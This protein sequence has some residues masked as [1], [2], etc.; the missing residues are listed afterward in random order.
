MQIKHA[1]PERE[2]INRDKQ[3]PSKKIIILLYF[4]VEGETAELDGEMKR[5]YGVAKFPYSTVQ[6]VTIQS[7]ALQRQE[8]EGSNKFN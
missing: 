6:V 8:V 5:S 7:L 3:N 4:I 1:Y 2:F